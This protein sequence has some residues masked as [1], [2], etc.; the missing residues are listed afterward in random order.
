LW[1]GKEGIVGASDFGGSGD[2]SFNSS[3]RTSS[4]EEK[5]SSWEDDIFLGGM[6]DYQLERKPTSIKEPSREFSAVTVRHCNRTLK[7]P[8]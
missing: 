3:S 6:E 7:F 1:D 5:A 2:T 8:R 4:L